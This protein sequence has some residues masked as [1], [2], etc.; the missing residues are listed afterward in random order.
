[1]GR[2][3][4][5]SDSGDDDAGP[6]QLRR[7]GSFMPGKKSDRVYEV[8]ADE[9][10]KALRGTNLFSDLSKEDT[11]TL[12]EILSMNHFPAGH[13]IFS[14]GSKGE[15]MYIVISG[16]INISRDWG[17]L[18]REMNIILSNNDFFGEMAIL[19]EHPRSANA[20]M[21][22]DGILLS[23]GKKEFRELIKKSPEFAINIMSTLCKR[24]RKANDDLAQLALETI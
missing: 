15:H 10:T 21:I 20:T 18:H 9:K 19:D 14:E 1:M 22:E 8:S 5:G 4:A 12:C 7:E 24:L 3:T 17:V 13:R 6:S 23:I 2:G 16:K 11:A